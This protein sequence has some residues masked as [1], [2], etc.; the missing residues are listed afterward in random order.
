MDLVL[1]E[2]GHDVPADAYVHL[3][4]RLAGGAG[5]GPATADDFHVLV[6]LA[7]DAVEKPQDE[8]RTRSELLDQKE[9]HVALGNGSH[10]YLREARTG[11]A[12]PEGPKGI[13]ADRGRRL[14]DSTC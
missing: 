8:L 2:N 11:H 12:H 1:N 3:G 9:V 6:G 14:A 13:L 10:E 5:D 4:V 7:V